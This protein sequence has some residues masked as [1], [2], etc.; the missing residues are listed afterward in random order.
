MGGM[1]LFHAAARSWTWLPL[2]LGIAPIA[3]HAAAPVSVPVT[4][5]SAATAPRS[6]AAFSVGVPL[7]PG[8]WR[9][10]SQVH[11]V[12]ADR[13][14]PVQVRVL[15][16]W[17]DDTARWILADWQAPLAAGESRSAR[18]EIGA[19]PRPSP[20][21]PLRVSVNAERIQVD[22]GSTRFAVPRTGA[23]LLTTLP[24][25]GGGPAALHGFAVVDGERHGTTGARQVEILESGPWRVRVAVHATYGAVHL[26]LRMD[27]FAGLGS[28][29]LLHTV[30]NHGVAA[31]ASL[32][33]LALVMKLGSTPT[34]LR[35]DA[36]DGTRLERKVQIDGARVLQS[37]ADTLR[38]D[39]ATSQGR[40]GG[41]FHVRSEAGHAALAARYFWQE[42][43][44]SVTA[45][46]DEVAYHLRAPT[47]DGRSL[48]F[49]SGAAKTHEL[50]ML[51]D[52]D[53]AEAEALA[54]RVHPAL[55]WVDPGYVQRTGALRNVLAPGPLTDAFVARLRESIAAYE[56]AQAREEWDDSRK[57]T[58]SD[59]DGNRRVGAY[60]MLHWGD[61]NFRG[62]RDDVKG[63]DAWGNLEYDTAQ[64][65]A[66]AYVAT[67]DPAHHD[68]MTAAARHFGDVDTI[69]FSAS[70]PAWIGMNH[71]KNPLHFTFEL[72]G[73]DLGHTWNEGLLSYGLFTGDERAI[74]TAR[75][76]AD[77]LVRRRTSGVGFRG[78]PRQ[79]GWPQVALVAAWELSGDQRYREAALWY[80]QRGIADRPPNDLGQWKTGILAEGVAYTHSATKDSTLGKWLEKY[81]EAVSTQ[82][83]KDPRFYP[84]L[85]Y[86]AHVHGRDDWSN[87]ARSVVDR[88]QLGRWGK[89]LTI[90][91]R[92]GL[93]SLFWLQ[94]DAAR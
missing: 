70:R 64:V 42:Y 86:A 91:G 76:I 34:H 19:P 83:P 93:S 4:L 85:A 45:V 51:F 92:I 94:A 55:A 36:A 73:V 38:I 41:W 43:P 28:V 56:I 11:F 17:P 10:G 44:Q 79:W 22:T 57:V 21:S 49:G 66:L 14:Q 31:S 2:A 78:N 60:G 33:Q 52:G 37:D 25:D 88:L 87:V 58:C 67:G 53:A 15:S 1:R 39:S 35:F 84:A 8:A 68:A 71:P 65:L 24:R 7:A 20:P 32:D 77:Y 16:R 75:G 90:G 29:R 9:D 3:A 18:L 81:A 12:D 72:G 46:G 62:Y 63:C 23:A 61:W 26:T 74:A 13:R 27:F 40:A 59:G 82:R 48:P 6:M 50:W 89:P 54:A 5:R 47:G 69:H 80:A 30:E